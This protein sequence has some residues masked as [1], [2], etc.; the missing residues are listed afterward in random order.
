MSASVAGMMFLK[1]H[2]DVWTNWVSPETAANVK[3]AIEEGRVGLN[4]KCLRVRG[5]N[6][7]YCK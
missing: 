2:E 1:R 7:F 3:A 5:E 4:Y 6:V